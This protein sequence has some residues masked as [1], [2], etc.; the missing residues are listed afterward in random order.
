M[1]EIIQYFNGNPIIYKLF[2]SFIILLV[3]IKLIRIA[4]K[5]LF[6]TIKDNGIYYTTRKRLYYLHSVILLVIFIIIWSESRMDLTIYVGF[7]SAGIAIALREIF[8][9]IA[10]LLIIV[11]Q[12]PFEVGDRVIVNDRAG[13]VIDQKIFHFVIMEVTAK[14]DGEQCTGK[15][16]HIPNN[17]IFL[18]AIANANK[19]FGYIWN[20][21]EVR[22]TIDSEWEEAKAQLETIV[23]KHAEHLTEEA[24]NKVHEASKKYMLHS[25][26]LNP[27]VYVTVKDGFIKLNMRYLTE[28][29]TSKITEDT[30]WREILLYVKDNKAVKLA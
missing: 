12:K 13:D 29:R 6:K 10:A 5:V 18:H 21:I 14:T 16:V 8:T 28:P 11:I 15:I 7:I 30:I 19:G 17:Y 26:N 24:K 20:E 22:L 4:N 1:Q 2:L 27:I 25:Q 9:N 23:K 3:Y